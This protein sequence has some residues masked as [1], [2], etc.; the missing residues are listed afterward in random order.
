MV[1]SS[2]FIANEYHLAF[3]LQK[4][5]HKYVALYTQLHYPEHPE[6]ISNKD[7]QELALKL[8]EAIYEI[9]LSALELKQCKS[10]T[11]ALPN[12]NHRS[13]TATERSNRLPC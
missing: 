10:E 4:C 13:I 11:E 2:K 6:S 12:E 3:N 5:F 1:A 8:Q 7:R 9:S